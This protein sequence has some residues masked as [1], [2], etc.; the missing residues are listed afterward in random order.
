MVRWMVDF[1][2]LVNKATIDIF[3]LLAYNCK[4][5]D[6]YLNALE[7]NPSLN[8]FYIIYEIMLIFISL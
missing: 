6:K 7:C 1:R 2:N 4:V 3:I 5:L 8:K